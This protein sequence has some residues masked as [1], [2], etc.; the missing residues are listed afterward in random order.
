MNNYKIVRFYQ[1][2][3][4]RQATIKEGLS[5]EEAKDHCSD[6]ETSST[7]AKSEESVA[8]TKE[9][10]KWFDGYRKEDQPNR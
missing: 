7:T 2:R 1:E 3:F 6:P 8:H 5:L 9:F 10:G 4:V